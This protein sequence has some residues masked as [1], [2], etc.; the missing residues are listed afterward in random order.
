[1]TPKDYNPSYE[2]TPKREVETSQAPKLAAASKA[3][4]AAQAKKTVPGMAWNSH[5]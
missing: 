2:V 5:G 4:A 3:I 1:M